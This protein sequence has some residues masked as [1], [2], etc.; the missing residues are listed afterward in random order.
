MAGAALKPN[1]L[2]QSNRAGEI[3]TECKNKQLEH[4]GPRLL[5]ADG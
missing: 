3:P 2:L 1:V 5:I 4:S